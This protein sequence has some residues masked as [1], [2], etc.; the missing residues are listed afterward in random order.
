LRIEGYE[1]DEFTNPVEAMRNFRDG[2]YQVVISDIKMPHID[3]LEVLELVKKQHPE[4][5]VILVTGFANLDNPT[6]ALNKGAYKFFRKPIHLKDLIAA[7]KEIE[8]DRNRKQAA[9]L[10]LSKNRS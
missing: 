2:N 8:D 10:H 3:G 7:L 4:T 6:V 1:V 9:K 5:H